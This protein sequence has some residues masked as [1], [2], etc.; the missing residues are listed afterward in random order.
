MYNSSRTLKG[1]FIHYIDQ[2]GIV[3]FDKN[4]WIKDNE[5]D[6]IITSD[7]VVYDKVD[8]VAIATDSALLKL[9]TKNDSTNA[10]DTLFMHADSLVSIPDSIDGEKIMVAYYGVRYYREDVQGVCDSLIYHTV[11]STMEMIYDPIVWNGGHQVVA[12]YIKMKQTG[13]R[14]SVVNLEDRSFITSIDDTL[15][16]QYNQVKGTD[17]VAYIDSGYMHRVEVTKNAESLYYMREEDQSL[18]GVNK[19]ES[20]EMVIWLTRQKAIDRIKLI[21]QVEGTLYPLEFLSE[22]DRYLRDFIWY[23]EERPKNKFDVF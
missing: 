22:E 8:D 23:R 11:D 10:T 7:K 4:V 13:E 19:V 3:N 12:K 21:N 14:S 16:A 17:I 9:V 18:L 5:K 1:D 2:K 15:K 6:I 20:G